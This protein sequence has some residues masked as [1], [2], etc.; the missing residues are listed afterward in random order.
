MAVTL[1]LLLFARGG[2][3]PKF[4]STLGFKRKITHQNRNG[5]RCVI[6]ECKAQLITKGVQPNLLIGPPA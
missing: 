4:T 5:L 3:N 6:G 2:L 1:L